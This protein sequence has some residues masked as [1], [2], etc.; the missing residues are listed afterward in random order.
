VDKHIRYEYKVKRVSW[1]TETNTWAV[2]S[3]V[4]LRKN[5]AVFM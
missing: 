4:G 1:S 2:E 3:E 5:C